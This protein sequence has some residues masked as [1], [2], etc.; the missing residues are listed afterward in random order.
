MDITTVLEQQEAFE[1]GRSATMEEIF[2]AEEALTV[3][4]AEEYRFYLQKYGWAS[5]KNHIFTG[6]SPFAGIDVVTVTKKTRKRQPQVPHE[7]YVIEET[8]M[9]GIVIWQSNDGTIYACNPSSQHLK[10]AESFA[11]Y[12]AQQ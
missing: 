2:K 8:Q 3:T 5:C 4:F 11:E 12:I 10:I 9:D 1:S 7:Y 6:I